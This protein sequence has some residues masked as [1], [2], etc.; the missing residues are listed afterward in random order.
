MTYILYGIFAFV[1]LLL[2]VPTSG[3]G[4]LRN[5]P[6]LILAAAVILCFFLYG[7]VKRARFLSNTKRLLRQNGFRISKSSAL[8]V[9]F[10][11]SGQY[12]IVCEK[13]TVWRIVL[14]MRKRSYLTYHFESPRRL[15]F[16]RTTRMVM[17]NG[18]QARATVTNQTETK[19]VGICLLP[20]EEKTE[21]TEAFLIMDRF[22]SRVTDTA[23][24]EPLGNG[25]T[26]AACFRIYD[27]KG[28]SV[29]LD[30]L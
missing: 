23:H 9:L 14:L 2:F 12:S 11:F 24:R 5:L 30:A 19:R 21:Y 17:K 26:V 15:E 10:G 28:F 3:D 13:E 4:Q 7:I 1:A 16:Y 25:D 22:P 8:F 18:G 20:F 27:K 6:L 29:F